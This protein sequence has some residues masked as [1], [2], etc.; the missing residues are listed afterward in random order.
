MKRIAFIFPGQGAQYPGMGKDFFAEFPEAKLTF[1]E[2]EDVLHTK[3]TSVIFDGPASSLNETAKS[4]VAIFVNS[5]AILRVLERLFPSLQPYVCAGLSLGEYSGLVASGRLDFPSCLRLVQRRAQ[6]MNDA[7][8]LTK[9][10]MA[11]VLGLEGD[12]VEEIVAGL[13]LPNDLWVA[14][15]NSPGQVVISGTQ[16]GIDAGTAAVKAKG[17]KRVLPLAVH[18]AFHSGLM[19]S[20]EKELAHDIQR[21]QLNDSNV[22]FVMNVPGDFVNESSQI[23]NFLIKQVT[24]SVRW[25]RGIRSIDKEGVDLYLEIGCGKTLQGLNKRIGTSAPTLGIEKVEEL[26]ELESVMSNI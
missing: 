5:I 18:G 15:F 12:E 22:K 26:K 19:Q 8:E 7:C 4:Q 2:A 14:N 17:A 9:G 6:L 16:K 24:S 1:Q 21:S 20:A 11:V 23:R 3:I 10:T 25:E 13:K